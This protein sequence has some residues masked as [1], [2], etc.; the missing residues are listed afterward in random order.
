M[1]S[2][3][4][5]GL[6][7]QQQLPL[8]DLPKPALAQ[9]VAHLEPACRLALVQASRSA[10]SAAADVL[11]GGTCAK[12]GA[13]STAQVAGVLRLGDV[14][15]L[16]LPDAWREYEVPPDAQLE[17]LRELV[18]NY[19]CALRGGGGCRVWCVWCGGGA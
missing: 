19:R 14:R 3:F 8:L 13:P 17:C 2:S 18:L 5:Q 16:L 1:D 11:C 12:F 7:L 4:S 10:F 9:V 6:Q 15:A